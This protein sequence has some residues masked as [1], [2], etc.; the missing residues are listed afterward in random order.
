LP[1]DREYSNEW[2]A[3][4]KK[5]I[6]RFT[7]LIAVLAPQVFASASSANGDDI[8]T[9]AAKPVIARYAWQRDLVMVIGSKLPPDAAEAIKKLHTSIPESELPEGDRFDLPP[10]PFLLVRD[11]KRIGSHFEMSLTSGPIP[12]GA[13]NSCGV[14]TIYIIVRDTGAKW[15]LSDPV[16]VAVC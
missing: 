5:A 11:F 1:A 9:A 10:G 4:L 2:R 13:I 12:K 6:H 7:V 14:T 15:K 3:T 16:S 8:W